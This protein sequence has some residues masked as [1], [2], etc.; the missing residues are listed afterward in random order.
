MKLVN[1]R[2]ATTILI[3]IVGC[4]IVVHGQANRS[5]T[6]PNLGGT[7]KLDHRKS[8]MSEIGKRDA[9]IKIVHND[10]ELRITRTL[11]RNGQPVEREFIYF[12][13]GRGETNSATTLLTTEPG[14]LKPEDIDKEIVKS[15]T[16]WQRDKVVMRAIMR[17]MTGSYILEYDIVD[18]WKI[19]TDG[20]TLTQISRIVVHPGPMSR[21][22]FVPAN[23]PDDKRVYNLVSK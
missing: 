15:R 6:R 5:Q 18:E 11:E 20:K 9:P 19:S 3:G 23:R 10:P 1:L 22:V 16:T 2:P 21:S 17:S 7:W 8:N 14:R 4:V 13:D 12:T